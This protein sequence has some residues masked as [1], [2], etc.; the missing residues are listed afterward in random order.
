MTTSRKPLSQMIKEDNLKEDI[1]NK[2]KANF[3]RKEY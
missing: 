3:A 1:K 2:Q